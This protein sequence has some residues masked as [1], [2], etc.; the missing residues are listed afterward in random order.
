MSQEVR[1]FL[2]GNDSGADVEAY[3]QDR[4]R[5]MPAGSCDA[6]AQLTPELAHVFARC[7]SLAGIVIHCHSFVRLF[8]TPIA[9]GAL[10]RPHLTGSLY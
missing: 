1:L 4:V 5:R 3:V 8:Q 9:R 2:L 6:R 7:K 10:S